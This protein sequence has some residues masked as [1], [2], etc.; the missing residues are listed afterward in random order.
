LN[1]WGRRCSS[2][3]ISGFGDSLVIYGAGATVTRDVPDHA[4]VVGNPARRI[5]W[6]CRCGERLGD[7]L[8]CPVC[9]AAYQE[10]ERGLEEIGLQEETTYLLIPCVTLR[11]NTERPVTVTQGTNILGTPRTLEKDLEE[12]ME[13]KVDGA[14]EFWDGNTAQRV[15]KAIK[16]IFV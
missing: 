7:D 4:L 3:H 16:S 11:S 2:G 15:V 8:V 5:G 6:M 13:R 12:V 9:G 10:S 14:P 1:N